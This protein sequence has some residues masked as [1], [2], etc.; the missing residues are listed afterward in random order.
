MRLISIK[1]LQEVQCEILIM[2]SIFTTLIITFIIN[3]ELTTTA[4]FTSDI[5]SQAAS[6]DISTIKFYMTFLEEILK[7]ILQRGDC[8]HCTA[9][10]IYFLYV[11]TV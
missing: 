5:K 8:I 6:P 2:I 9:T 10:R 3:I 1:T 11:N 4:M 7:E